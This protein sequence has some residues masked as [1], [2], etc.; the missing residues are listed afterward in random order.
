MAYTN[1]QIHVKQSN[2]FTR[3]FQTVVY[4][5]TQHKLNNII[6]N[7][8]P[9]LSSCILVNGAQNG[10]LNGLIICR[11]KVICCLFED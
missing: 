4:N 6:P 3:V 9:Y 11:R 8:C 5:S 2:V 10:Y 7:T 1:N